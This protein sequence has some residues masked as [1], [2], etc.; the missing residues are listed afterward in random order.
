MLNVAFLKNKRTVCMLTIDQIIYNIILI[1]LYSIDIIEKHWK[2]LLQAI[3]DS[4]KVAQ[5]FYDQELISREYY[6]NFKEASNLHVD[7]AA[8][9]ILLNGLMQKASQSLDCTQFIYNLILVMEDDDALKEIAIDISK[10]V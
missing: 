10:F 8:A 6:D 4:S 9:S 5:V 7:E 3:S 1:F 2:R